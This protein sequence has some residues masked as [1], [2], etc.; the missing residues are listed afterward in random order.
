MNMRPQI[1]GA[2]DLLADVDRGI[3]YYSNVDI[4]M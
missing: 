2:P 3:Q 4:G 1:A